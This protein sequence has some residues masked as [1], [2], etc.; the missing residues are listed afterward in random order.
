[1]TVILRRYAPS[2]FL[3]AVLF[4]LLMNSYPTA[5]AAEPQSIWQPAPG[6]TWQWQLTTPIDASVDAQVYDIDLFD[7]DAATVASLHAAGRRVVC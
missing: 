7:N 3:V 6:T 4:G 2:L 5:T 1:M